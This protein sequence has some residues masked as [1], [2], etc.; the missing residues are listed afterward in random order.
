MLVILLFLVGDGLKLETMSV[1]EKLVEELVVKVAQLSDAA[2]ETGNEQTKW[3]GGEAAD[4][5]EGRSL[6]S[7]K[8]KGFKKTMK[9]MAFLLTQVSS[10]KVYW[11]FLGESH[12]YASVS[13]LWRVTVS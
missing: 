5:L 7:G 8:N 2:F 6:N 12:Q 11:V 4:C 10:E 3:Q 1:V 13:K 9:G